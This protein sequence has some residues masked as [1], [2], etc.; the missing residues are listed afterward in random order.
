MP[1]DGS[2]RSKYHNFELE[3][4]FNA[5]GACIGRVVSGYGVT[6]FGT[7]VTVRI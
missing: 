1:V 7:L 3:W 4:N 5:R 2:P 6:F